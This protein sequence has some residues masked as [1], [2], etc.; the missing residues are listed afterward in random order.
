MTLLNRLRLLFRRQRFHD[1]LNEEM[2]FHRAQA[3]KDL[4]A[5]G[6]TPEAARTAAARRFG[7]ATQIS[8]RSH[9]TVSFRFENTWH[10]LRYGLRQLWSNPGFTIVILLTLA[11][12]IGANSAIFSV[13]NG[14]LLKRLPYPQAD[15]L[16]R[17]FLS[18]SSFPKFPLNPF[19]FR[20]FRARNR[21]FESMAA[22]TRGDVQLSG[23]ASPY[24]FTVSA[25]P[26]HTFTCSACNRN[27]GASLIMRRRFLAMG[28]RSFSAIASGER[29]LMPT[30]P[31]SGARSP[32][33]CSPSQ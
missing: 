26:R 9:E 6:M 14:V 29:G 10:D 18:N 28:Y 7:N 33:T 27:L 31:L 30:L 16:V 5:E 24:A 4:V 17:I 3:E 32:S 23:S 1:E 11:L 12:S 8:E 25:S 15:R 20:D 13:I 19:D 2:A 22:F 21:S